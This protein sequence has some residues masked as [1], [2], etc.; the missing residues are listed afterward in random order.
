MKESGNSIGY[1]YPH[2]AL[3]G[4]VDEHY[5]PEALKGSIFYEP[6]DRGI[7]AQIGE[8]L[9]RLRGARTG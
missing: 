1:R 3:G 4:W 7:D 6:T 9:R 8:K 5:L 2:D